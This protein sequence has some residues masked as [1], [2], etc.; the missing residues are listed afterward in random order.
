M[1][2]KQIV[3]F[4][5]SPS[6]TDSTI[7]H[8][9][10]M[11]V[12]KKI[13]AIDMVAGIASRITPDASTSQKGVVQ[14]SNSTTSNS[15]TTAATSLAVS[16]VFNEFNILNSSI[17]SAAF[18]DE[19]DYATADQGL[20]ASTALQAADVGSAAYEDKV[21]NSFDTAPGKITDVGWMGYGVPIPLT[22]TDAILSLPQIEM[23]NQLF[24]WGDFTHPTGLPFTGAGDAQRF[25]TSA[26]SERLVVYEKSTSKVWTNTKVSGTW[27]GWSELGSG[28]GGG[29]PEAPIDGRQYARKDATWTQVIT[30]ESA[31]PGI[32]SFGEVA[33]SGSQTITMDLSQGSAFF[34]SLETA[35]TTGTLSLDF[36]NIPSSGNVDGYIVIQRAGRKA[37]N[38]PTGSRYAGGLVPTYIGTSGSTTVIQ[39]YRFS[40]MTPGRFIFAVNQ[41]EGAL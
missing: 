2:D 12:N 22:T 21:D 31:D 9:W 8:I 13:A 11:G 17:G 1:A 19:A 16:T 14:L 28:S 27:L 5:S 37:I 41:G 26:N 30:S 34:A 7:F 29:I 32:I 40:N 35:V 4:P 6:F 15:Q 38:L 18:T 23:S 20:L 10:D 33:T 39:F 3:D 25:T 24:T 36:S